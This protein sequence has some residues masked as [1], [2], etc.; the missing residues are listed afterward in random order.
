MRSGIAI[1]IALSIVALFAIFFKRFESE[2]FEDK[3]KCDIIIAK[4]FPDSPSVNIAE[5]SNV[6]TETTMSSDYKLFQAINDLRKLNGLPPYTY[7]PI[8]S[9]VAQLHMKYWPNKS[10]SLCN[11]HSWSGPF[12]CCYFF[13]GK[14]V[15][16]PSCM[17]DKVR[18][19]SG[20]K[21][22]PNGYEIFASEKSNPKNAAEIWKKSKPHLDVILQKD[23]WGFLKMCGCGMGKNG[24]SC[25][26]Q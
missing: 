9:K 3:F 7:S 18:Q 19:I 8:L 12:E 5:F 11:S 22:Q 24:S 26:F 16:N 4:D 20:D 14:T 21:A 17:W 25:W 6:N 13:D 15:T 1:I 2:E 23:R 10:P